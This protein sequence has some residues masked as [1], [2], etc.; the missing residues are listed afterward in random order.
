MAVATA[1]MAAPPDAESGGVQVAEIPDVSTCTFSRLLPDPSSRRVLL[2]GAGRD[3]RA[4]LNLAMPGRFIVADLPTDDADGAA[5]RRIVAVTALQRIE[6]LRW[7]GSG[8]RLL[9]RVGESG[10][11]LLDPASLA[12]AAAPDI[13][14][15]WSRM[16]IRAISH[17]GTNFY[18]DYQALATLRRIERDGRPVRAVAT[19]GRSASFLAFRLGNRHRLTAYRA[20]HSWQTGIALPFAHAPLLADGA[21]RPTFLGDQNGYSTFLPYAMPLPDLASGQIAGRFGWER[22]ELRGGRTIDLAPLFRQLINILDAAANGD[23]VFALVDLEREMR[24]VRIRGDEIRS[25]PLCEKRGLQVGPRL[26]PAMNSLSAETPVVRTEIRF[27]SQTGPFGQLYRPLRANGRLIVYFHGGPTATL[28][29]RTVPEEVSTFAAHGISV[30]NVEYSG[31]VGGGLALSERLPRLGFRALRQDVE[32]IT[33]WVRGSGFRRVYL[34]ADSFGGAPAVIAAVEHPGDYEHIFLRAPFLAL[35]NPEQSVRRGQML[36][37]DPP[38]DSQLEFE[39]MVYGGARGRTRFGADLQAYVQRLRPSPRLSFYFGGIDPV[40]AATDLP[41]AF[42]GD[43]S[44]M[45]LPR[46]AHEFV[47]ADWAIR[48]D[49]VSKIDRDPTP[50]GAPGQSRRHAQ[51]N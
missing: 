18:R 46:T 19:I 38:A 34:L 49:I 43:R 15:L 36:S 32:A 39:R 8:D 35:R 12:L 40:S 14:P 13:D 22:I 45:I 10:A 51:G 37:R 33:A 4:P 26:F 48:D 41:P 24:V 7:S 25:W 50:A 44:V 17:G 28:A 9:F 3:L 21:R 27:G 16:R 29:E 20:G 5:M 23:T 31:M 11:R 42:A 1:A 30:L 47:A 2:G 6:P